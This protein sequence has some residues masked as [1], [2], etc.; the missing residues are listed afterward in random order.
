M[1]ELPL[2]SDLWYYGGT[3][4]I[5]LIVLVSLTRLVSQYNLLSTRPLPLLFKDGKVPGNEGKGG[6][7]SG[8]GGSGSGKGGSGGVK[9]GAMSGLL[10][11]VAG[12]LV[13]QLVMPFGVKAD[14]TPDGVVYT[15]AGTGYCVVINDQEDLLTEDEESG[16]LEQM[17]DLTRYGNAV[18][19]SCSQTEYSDTADYAKNWY[20]EYFGNESGTTLMIDMGQRMIAKKDMSLRTIFTLMLQKAITMDARRAHSSRS[21]H[22]W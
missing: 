20:F 5:F 14:G 9:P 17:K 10:V 11:L 2:V 19:V 21:R 7:G 4:T 16:L 22:C 6:S 15:D 12:A 18:F 1:R 13:M 8:K 3:V